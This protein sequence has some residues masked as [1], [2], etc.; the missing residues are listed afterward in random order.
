MELSS[1]KP[2]DRLT[3][4][5]VIG[6]LMSYLDGELSD[7]LRAKFEA[8]LEKCTACTDYLD[9]YTKT[10]ALGK[11]SFEEPEAAVAEMPDELVEAILAARRK[12]TSS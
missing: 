1:S 8:H 2:S 7:E 4:E 9:G 12:A 11:E 10:V 5:Q 3:C 6:F